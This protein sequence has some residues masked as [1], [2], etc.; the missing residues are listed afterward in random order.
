M[1]TKTTKMIAMMMMPTMAMV[2][3]MTMNVT[4]MV[5][6]D[7]NDG[8]N[9]DNDGNDNDG[10]DDDNDDNDDGGLGC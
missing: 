4:I 2:I 10:N 3:G 1:M 8:D 7:A 5:Y 9:G 6:K